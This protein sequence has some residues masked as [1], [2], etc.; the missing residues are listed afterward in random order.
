MVGRCNGWD[1]TAFYF[2]VPGFFLYFTEYGVQYGIYT[3][4]KRG[5]SRQGNRSSE[6]AP[7]LPL[8]LWSFG[9]SRLSFPSWPSREIK[10]ICTR[11]VTSFHLGSICLESVGHRFSIPPRD[12]ADSSGATVCR[13]RLSVLHCHYPAMNTLISGCKA[14]KARYGTLDVRL[15]S[16]EFSGYRKLSAWYLRVK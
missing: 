13:L 7:L 2:Q 1:G 14:R 4:Y 10:T 9:P 15:R 8:L 3:K 5:V 6:Y 11:A 16:R 12:L